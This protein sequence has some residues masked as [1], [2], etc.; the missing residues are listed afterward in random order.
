MGIMKVHPLADKHCDTCAFY[1]A[2]ASNSGECHANAPTR[3]SDD[4]GIAQWPIVLSQDFCGGWLA[5]EMEV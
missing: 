5:K 2:D 1:E 3:A 4:D